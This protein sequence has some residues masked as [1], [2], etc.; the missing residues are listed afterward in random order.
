MTPLDAPLLTRLEFGAIEFVPMDHEMYWFDSGDRGE[1][2]LF[3][4]ANGVLVSIVRHRLSY[5]GDRGQYEIMTLTDSEPHGRCIPGCTDEQGI[6]GHLE[7]RDVTQLLTKLAG[8]N[9]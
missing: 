3:R 1:Q 8:V 2:A 6:A 9:I 7:P 4:L 5:G